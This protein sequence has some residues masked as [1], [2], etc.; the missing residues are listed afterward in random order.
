[1]PPVLTDRARIASELIRHVNVQRAARAR[2]DDRV[3]KAL[4]RIL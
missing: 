1:V 4:G 2:E 3:A